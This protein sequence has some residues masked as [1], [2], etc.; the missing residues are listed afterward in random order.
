[1]AAPSRA[2][3]VLTAQLARPLVAALLACS[4]LKAAAL[5]GDDLLSLM[6]A[7]E[8]GKASAVA[9]IRGFVDGQVALSSLVNDQADKAPTFA[10]LAV[11]GTRGPRTLCPPTG[12][13]IQQALEIVEVALRA[14]PDRQNVSAM[15]LTDEALRTAW[16]CR[17][18]P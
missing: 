12:Y 10:T 14:R 5:T 17:L 8:A 6:S 13:S 3:P 18:A 4:A 7:D 9:Y 1:M 15:L 2:R 16:P 11:F